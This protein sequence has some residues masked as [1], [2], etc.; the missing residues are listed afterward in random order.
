MQLVAN[1]FKKLSDSQIIMSKILQ[2][3]DNW[4][5]AGNILFDTA[6]AV[7][8]SSEELKITTGMQIDFSQVEEIDTTAVSLMLGWKRRA[9]EENQKISFVNLPEN[10]NSLLHLYGVADLIC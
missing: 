2:N 6:G 7:F 9:I 3:G 5:V 1:K 8:K 4:Q 10:L